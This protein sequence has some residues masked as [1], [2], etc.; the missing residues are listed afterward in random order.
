VTGFTNAQ[1]QNRVG[2]VTDF[3]DSG[4]NTLLRKCIVEYGKLPFIDMRC[5][6]ACSVSAFIFSFIGPCKLD[7]SWIQ[8]SF[9]F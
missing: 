9:W 1:N 5:G 8:I 4:I 3:T 6:Y 7:K 2:V